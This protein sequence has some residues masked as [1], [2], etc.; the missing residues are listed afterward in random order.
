MVLVVTSRI[1]EFLGII[2]TFYLFFKGYK[3]KYVF[4]VGGIVLLSITSSLVSLFVRDYFYHIALGDLAVTCLLL[5]GVLLYVVRNP[6]KT[7]DFTPPE[8]ARCPFCNA[9]IVR[10]EGLCTMRVGNH[11]LFFDS[12]DHLVRFLKEAE[13]LLAKGK[14]PKGKVSDVFLKTAD[15]GVWRTPDKVKVVEREGTYT[16]YENPPGEGESLD[17]KGLLADFK[18]KV[19]GN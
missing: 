6:E 17:L 5:F 16:A 8:D 19:G 12:C 10:E 18:N 4:V 9:L 3:A 7:R 2:M 1:V 13:F 15:T 14:V 11:V